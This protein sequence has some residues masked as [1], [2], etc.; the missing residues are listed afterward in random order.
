MDA[1]AASIG[2][3]IVMNLRDEASNGLEQLRNQFLATKVG[4]QDMVANFDAGVTRFVGGITAMAAGLGVLAVAFMG[5]TKAAVDFQAAMAEVNTLLDGEQVELMEQFSDTALSMGERFGKSAK[6]MAKAMYESLSAGVAVTDVTKFMETASK[7]AVGGVTDTKTAVDGLSSVMNAFKLDMQGVQAASD[8]MFVAMKLGKTTIGELA[9]SV[10]QIAPIAANAKV[11]VDEMFGSIAAATMSGQTTAEATTGIRAAMMA[12][13]SPSEQAE[14]TAAAM[15]IQFNQSALASKGLYRTLMDVV[16]A[17]DGD[18]KKLAD[19]FGSV[20]AL[21]AV[22]NVTANGGDNFA[23]VMKAMGVK[24]GAADEAF[25]KMAAT[26]KFKWEQMKAAFET[27]SIKLGTVLLPILGVIVAPF[28]WLGQKLA[29]LPKPLYAVI[30]GAIAFVGVALT[31]A[32][33]VMAF[34]G[35][36]RLWTVAQQMYRAGLAAMSTATKGFIATLWRV[37]LPMAA[38]MA[39]SYLLYTAW[40]NNFGG[41]RDLAEAIAAGFNMAVSAG[42]DGIAQVDA[43]VKEKLVQMGVWDTAV[44]M[45]KVFFRIRQFLE[46][47]AAGATEVFQNIANVGRDIYTAI[48]PA[49]ETGKF[50]LDWILKLAGIAETSSASWREWGYALGQ[51]FASVA[52][53]F[54]A[55]KAVFAIKAIALSLFA[56]GSTA[57]TVIGWIATGIAVLVPALISIAVTLVSTVIPAII[58]LGV[59]LLTNPFFWVIAAIFAIGFAIDWLAKNWDWLKVKTLEIWNGISSAISS[60]WQAVVGYVQAAWS[61]IVNA[62]MNAWMS[63]LTVAMTIVSFFIGLW[64][65]IY[66]ACVMVWDNIKLAVASAWNNITT[67]VQDGIN[68]VVSFITGMGSTLYNSGAAL[69]QAFCDGIKS[70]LSAPAD[71]VRQ[72]LQAVRNLLPFSDAREGPL[73]TLTLSGERLVTTLTGGVLAAMPGLHNAVETGLADLTLALPDIPQP[74]VPDATGLS[75][76]PTAP[77]LAERT[78]A[79]AAPQ[80][81]ASIENRLNL[82]V[83][84]QEV[85]ITLDGNEIGRAAVEYAR[86]ENMRLGTEG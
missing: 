38:M 30:A 11:S 75:A 59:A 14:K 53:A 56:F 10:G 7:L 47:F 64:M 31:A 66:D 9:R 44:M 21:N 84:P 62:A 45:G 76:S 67:A 13:L 71:I 6:E 19:L 39:L 17:A 77:I 28:A 22:L 42:K 82:Q 68:A 5:P 40:E 86:Y 70:V 83:T 2:L 12:L 27:F 78:V 37:A 34:G 79:F 16:A 33:A 55:F 51:I 36:M 25:A 8:S 18:T 35:A 50:L 54:V 74:A 3:G 57:V 52:A 4:A 61:S 80:S 46:G 85:V 26:F 63:I 72:G 24:A 49:L 41:I 43:S 29:N 1:I 23:K 32:G 69:W 73:S 60:A 15:G 20:E 81:P 58:S 65:N 48:A